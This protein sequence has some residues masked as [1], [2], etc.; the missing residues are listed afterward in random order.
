[1]QYIA[2]YKLTPTTTDLK[3][4]FFQPHY[5]DN[6]E[7]ANSVATMIFHFFAFGSYASGLLGAALADS[8]AGPHHQH[9]DLHLVVHHHIVL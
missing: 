7:E 1:M 5:P 2:F 6:E 4:S 9:A 3:L 8:K